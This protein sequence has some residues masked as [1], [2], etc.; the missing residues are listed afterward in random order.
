MNFFCLLLPYFGIQILILLC[1]QPKGGKWIRAARKELV[2]MQRQ[3]DS[4]LL[5][6]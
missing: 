6:R 5:P 1:R 3:F 4:C 2:A